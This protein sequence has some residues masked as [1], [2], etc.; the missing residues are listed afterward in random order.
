LKGGKGGIGK[1]IY[2]TDYGALLYL[3]LSPPNIKKINRTINN[4]FIE[5]KEIPSSE[6]I[7]ELLEVSILEES[8]MI[9][10]EKLL[11]KFKKN[12]KILEGIIDKILNKKNLND[13]KTEKKKGEI[14]EKVFKEQKRIGIDESE[15]IIKILLDKYIEKNTILS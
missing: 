12:I 5:L 9:A 6:N 7:A 8:Y 1:Y 13:I 4:C 3:V 11:A 14:I 10:I 15:G 2:H